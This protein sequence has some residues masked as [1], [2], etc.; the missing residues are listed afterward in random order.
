MNPSMLVLARESRG[1]TQSRVSELSGLSQGYIS[2]LEKGLLAPSE[3]RLARLADSLEY[4]VE[5]FLR[6]DQI[7]G[8]GS[9]CI[10]HRKRASMPITE[11]RVVQARINVLRI[12]IAELLRG[13]D[14]E[15][16]NRFQRMD[17]DEFESPERVARLVRRSWGLP[18]GPIENLVAA[19]ESAGGIVYRMAFG[20]QKLDAISQWPP[21][22]PPL[23]FINADL[24]EDRI[25]FSIAHE[26]GHVI[27][28]AVPTQD[29]EREADRF[30][31]EFL[32]PAKEIANEL[33]GLDL[34]RAAELKPYWRVSMAALIMHAKRL[35]QISASKAATLYIQLG[36]LGYRRSEPLPLSI[37]RPMLVHEM[38]RVYMEEQRLT[39]QD[40][41]RVLTIREREFRERFL[42]PDRKLR[43]LQA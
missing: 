20:S 10:Y 22:M 11:L 34:V 13:V 14:I 36:K 17:V 9:L 39:P 41:S 42:I 31:A 12:Q 4:P 2:K 43:L 38:V 15:V 35:G 1:Y 19:L 32:M 21:D 27:M 28:H 29:M 5:F 30:A 18:L 16:E 6:T 7:F 25:R 24:T 33:A 40:L 8:F 3:D 23:L 26:L 37:E